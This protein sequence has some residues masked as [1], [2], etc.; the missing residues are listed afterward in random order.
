MPITQNDTIQTIADQ[1]PDLI[2]QFEKSGFA[3]Y[4][5]PESLKKIGRFTRLGTLLRSANIDVEAFLGMLN[6]QLSQGAA[7]ST[8]EKAI[9]ELHFMAMLPCGLRNP[10]KDFLESH[11]LDHPEA[12]AG[13]DYLT[14]GNVNHELSYYPMLDHVS[15]ADE[16]PEIMLASDVNNFFHRPFQERFVGKGIFETFTPYTPNPYLEKSGFADPS[17]NYTMLTANMLVMAVDTER[18]GNTPIPEVWSDLLSEAFTDEIIMRGEDDFF[19][20]AIMLPFYKEHGF[21][22]IRQMAQNIRTGKHPAEMVKLA[23]KGG[24]DAAT[25]YIMPYFF[26]KKIKNPNVKLLW[27]TDG[28]IA[29]PVFMMVRKSAMEKHCSLLNFLLSKETGELLVSRFFPA[30]HPDVKNTLPEPVKWLGWDFLN[31]ND[32]G[33]LKDEIRDVFMEVWKQK[34]VV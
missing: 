21:Y 2:P 24:D 11:I 19:C 12:Y 4:F 14:E 20:N 34:A 22:A 6:E 31:N 13:L 18:L 30:I 25:I 16:L 26:A 1:Y 23:D 15:S 7:V 28:A 32:I 29:S 5:K 27:P 33:K 9:H 3:S 8:E 17:G 10:F